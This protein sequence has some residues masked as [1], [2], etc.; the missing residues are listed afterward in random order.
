VHRLYE[1]LK[2][3][4]EQ[5]TFFDDYYSGRHPLPWLATQAREEFRRILEMT[6]SNYMGLV[7]DAVVERVNVE[8]FRF[9]PDDKADDETWRIFQ[10][11]HLDQDSDTAWLESTISGTS[12]FKVSPNRDD[13]KFPHVHIVHASQV[14]V[15]HVPGTNRRK[16]AA[17]LEVWEDDWTGGLRATL[18]LPDDTDNVLRI[19]KY[20]ANKEPVQEGTATVT[21][22]YIKPQW[23]VWERPDEEWGGAVSE[24]SVVPIIEIPNNPR[25]LTGGISE[26]YDLTDIQDRIN[27]TLADRL[28]T[29]D[30]GAFPQKWISAW[31]EEDNA[32]N[33]TPPID[34]G[35]NRIITTDIKEAKFGQFGAA[36][37]DPYSAAKREDV[38]D[39][40]S[41]SRTPAQYLLGEL[42]NVNGETLK[43]SESGL[44]SKVKQRRKP[45]GEA[46]EETMRLARQLAGLKGTDSSGEST[47]HMMETIWSNP[48]YRTEGELVDAVVKKLQ[49][50]IASLRQAREDAGYSVT[51]IKRLEQEDRQQAV[52]AMEPLIQRALRPDQGLNNGSEADAADQLVQ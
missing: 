6:R 24:L 52:N 39:I 30:Y 14:I 5:V 32:G 45:W 20:Q 46:I 43:A 49:V 15:E 26:L 7:C 51:Q 23:Q 27:K 41:R 8:G 2:V 22:S 16:R 9:G 44:V 3:R 17:A 19:Y 40:A 33:P 36:D 29:Q 1:K 13:P 37:L 21:V 47:E 18:Y 42:T 12:H 34:V 11:N 35:R 50:G 10:F 31:P 4:Q 48:E 28:I 38:K 25:L